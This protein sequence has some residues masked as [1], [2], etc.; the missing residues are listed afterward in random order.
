LF[1]RA[2]RADRQS[3][4]EGDAIG[5]KLEFL[6]SFNAGRPFLEQKVRD[7]LTGKDRES[8]TLIIDKDKVC[9]L[10]L[11]FAAHC[12]SKE[13]VR[14]DEIFKNEYFFRFNCDNGISGELNLMI[15][16]NEARFY[17]R[18]PEVDRKYLGGVFFEGC[19]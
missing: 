19:K 3:V 15:D 1:G 8:V 18:G 2:C 9:E 10:D 16:K 13:E 14:N 17:C 5:G 12:T 7:N 4:I 11:D 6:A